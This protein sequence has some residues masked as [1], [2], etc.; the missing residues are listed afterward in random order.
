MAPWRK[1]TGRSE[2]WEQHT[3]SRGRLFRWW[4]VRITTVTIDCGHTKVF[5]GDGIPKAKVRC[6][7]C[8]ESAPCQ[9]NPSA[10]ST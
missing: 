3:S 1:I 10:A 2:K 5:R 6:P 9:A 8:L 7:A 4:Q